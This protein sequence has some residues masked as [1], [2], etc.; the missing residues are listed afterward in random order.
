MIRSLRAHDK[1]YDMREGSGE[2]FAI[3]VH[4]TGRIVF[5]T[6]YEWAGRRRR[7]THGTYPAL[8]L[9]NARLK[10]REAMQALANGVDPMA[11]RKPTETKPHD[12][13]AAD[14]VDEYIEVY[15]RLK[16]KSWRV[17]QRVLHKDFIPAL[18]KRPLVDI[19]PRDIVLLLDKLR[20][21]D[22]P[23]AAEQLLQILKRLFGVA[24]ERGVIR[25]EQNPAQYVK[26]QVRIREVERA[27]TDSELVIA[28]TLLEY[29]HVSIRNALRFAL[30]T[31][32]RINEAAQLPWAEI[33]GDIWRLPAHRAKQK[34]EHIRP[35]SSAAQAILTQ[36]RPITH[37]YV[38]G[39][40]NNA[41]QSRDTVASALRRQLQKQHPE[42]PTFTPHD[43]R[44][45]F[46]TWAE[47]EGINPVVAERVLGH[48]LGKLTR[49]YN[50]H[51]YIDEMRSAL[52]AWA[53][54]ISKL[55]ED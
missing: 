52:E 3:R 1:T 2:G 35:L 37:D 49:V 11:A 29:Q 20:N 30:L 27:L 41:P 28:W 55:I 18:G 51:G 24:V 26:P 40:N 19:Q 53:R 47:R 9:K 43:L 39:V 42:I 33:E 5:C 46:R 6:W 4:P 16:K 8:S 34:R 38:F 15:A 10:H 12:I 36:Q 50:R 31:A 44:R 23:Y 13:L 45:T 48:S 54:H 7:I 32:A 25:P 14:F 17:D 21:R 22:A